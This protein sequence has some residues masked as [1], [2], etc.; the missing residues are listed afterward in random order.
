MPVLPIVIEGTHKALPKRGFVVRGRHP[1]RI[2]VLEPLPVADFGEGDTAALAG[3]VRGI[4][5]EH[6]AESQAPR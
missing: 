2:T 5:A 3:H 1:I 6:L 4:I